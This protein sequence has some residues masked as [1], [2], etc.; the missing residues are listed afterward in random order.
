MKS[1]L[2]FKKNMLSILL[3]NV[4]NILFKNKLDRKSAVQSGCEEAKHK[5]QERLL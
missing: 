4:S 1:G 5:K 3:E 2:R